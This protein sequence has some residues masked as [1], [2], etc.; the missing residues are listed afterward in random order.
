M[1][2]AGHPIRYDENGDGPGGDVLCIDNLAL[3]YCF[4]TPTV[5][6]GLVR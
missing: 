4:Y 6:G 2:A 5:K 3:A 1:K